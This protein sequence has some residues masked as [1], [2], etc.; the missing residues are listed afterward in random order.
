MPLRNRLDEVIK[1]YDQAACIVTNFQDGKM[2]EEE[3]ASN[4]KKLRKERRSIDE[5]NRAFLVEERRLQWGDAMAEEYENM[6]D[7]DGEEGSGGES[8]GGDSDDAAEEEDAENDTDGHNGDSTPR[9]GKY[10]DSF[11]HK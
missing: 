1:R 9:R 5:H 4:F 10:H 3:L 2:S 8:V 11:F 6:S 7:S